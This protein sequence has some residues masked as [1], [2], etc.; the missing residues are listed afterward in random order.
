MEK[1]VSLLRIFII[2]MVLAMIVILGTV[3]PLCV[4]KDASL[5][6]G[7]FSTGVACLILTVALMGLSVYDDYR[8]TSSLII[9]SMLCLLAGVL[10]LRAG[11]PVIDRYSKDFVGMKVDLL[12]SSC[13][14]IAFFA[15]FINSCRKD[16]LVSG[17]CLSSGGCMVLSF[18]MMWGGNDLKP[19]FWATCGCAIASFLTGGIRVLGR[20]KQTNER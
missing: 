15:G 3:V 18:V 20:K 17:Y 7:L 8:Q 14:T 11:Y 4:D 9:L 10:A 5:G 12:V 6:P 2:A 13:L 16:M 19:Y 1:D